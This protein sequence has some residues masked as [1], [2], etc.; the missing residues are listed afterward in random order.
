LCLP[1]AYKPA[2]DRPFVFVITKDDQV[3][4]R[5]VVVTQEADALS[6]IAAGLREGE[7]LATSGFSQLT[8][9]TRVSVGGSAVTIWDDHASASAPLPDNQLRQDDR[10]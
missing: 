5:P 4:V 10:G 7:R 8:D 3:V 2:P 9:G 6:V 1:T